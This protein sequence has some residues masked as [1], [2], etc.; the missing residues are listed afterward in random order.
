M[1]ERCETGP[2]S[3]DKT[4]LFCWEHKNVPYIVARFGLTDHGTSTGDSNPD[5]GVGSPI[6]ANY[7]QIFLTVLSHV[8][9][10]VP[11]QSC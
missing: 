3:A 2:S 9:H 6:S 7:D 4:V 10:C 8:R 5:S 1:K 11:V